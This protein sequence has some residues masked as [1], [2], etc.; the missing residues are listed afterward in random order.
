MIDVKSSIHLHVSRHTL[1]L[2]G[3]FGSIPSLCFTLIFPYSII[4]KS[5]IRIIR[6]YIETDF[7]TIIIPL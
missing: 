3:A 5:H 1:L 6:N 2:C 7:F 4:N